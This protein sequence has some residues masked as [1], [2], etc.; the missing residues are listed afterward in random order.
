MSGD[1]TGSLAEKQVKSEF[2]DKIKVERT[3]GYTIYQSIVENKHEVFLLTGHAGD[4]KTSI[5]AQVLAS[6]GKLD[7]SL[8]LSEEK[9]QDGFYYVK[10]MSEISSTQQVA[11]LERVLT[12]PQHQKTSLLISNTGPLLKSMIQLLVNDAEKSGTALSEGETMKIQNLL[13]Q[14]LDKNE[15]TSI[16]VGK[17][18]FQL[19]NIARLDNVKFSSEIL[20]NFLQDDLW[21]P[22]KDCTK[23]EVCPM[24]S[25]YQLLSKK[26]EQVSYFIE[27]FYRYLY[28]CD[29][30]MTIRQML[31]QISFALTGNLTCEQVHEKIIPHGVFQY[32]FANL[33]FGY[34]GTVEKPEFRQIK[35]ID[36]I[37]KLDLDGIS[38]KEDYE[39][40]VE[41]KRTY[42]SKDLEQL[43]KPLLDRRQRVYRMMEPDSKTHAQRIQEER[44]ER[45]AV[46]RFFHF[47]QYFESIARRD[48]FSNQIY[49]ARFS[50]YRDVTEKVQTSAKLKKFNKL[51]F[52]ALYMRNTGFVYGNSYPNL[53][54]TLRR[55]N[56]NFQSVMMV[57]GEVGQNEIEVKQVPCNNP[58][59]DT[60]G[61]Q[62]LVLKIKNRVFPLSYPLIAYFSRLILGDISC[63]NNPSLTHGIAA[64]DAMLI[65]EFSSTAGNEGGEVSLLFRTTNG[66]EK[67]TFLFDNGRLT[68]D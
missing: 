35:G 57:L 65:E 50:D 17:Y 62:Q 28:E 68:Q 32:N 40:F 5:L 30:R 20:S 15:N 11:T 2:F 66:Q 54:L 67:R 53:P 31:G 52:E 37:R 27:N 39:I 34:K 9:D 3:L 38:L 61:R 18:S 58:F 45:K 12:A 24:H 42:F 46:R 26:L 29:K 21:T 47:Y 10:D 48:D 1:S 25:N 43:L 56:S 41:K 13:L 7:K 44:E 60:V 23:Q 55:D 36:Q 4:G 64:L 14:Q 49:G 51:I 59:E 33:F 22:C 8:G 19:I 6:L 16:S 63:D